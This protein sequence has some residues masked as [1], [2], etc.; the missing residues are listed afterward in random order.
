MLEE[1]LP[2]HVLAG[3]MRILR[4][5]ASAALVAEE[6]EAALADFQFALRLADYAR[7]QPWVM[8]TELQMRGV[9]DT[10][11][12]LWEGLAARRWDERQLAAAQAQLE[13]LDL[14]SDF[15]RSVRNDAIAQSSFVERI[16]PT[17]S[18]T[19]RVVP[20]PSPEDAGA[21]PMIRLVYPKGWSLQSQAAIHRFHLET[22][23]RYL[24]ADARRLAV[25]RREKPRG[26]FASSD[27]LYRVFMV[28][29]ML[30]IFVD[31]AEN[32]PFAQTA[33]DLATLACALERYRLAQGEFPA[34]LAPLEPRF[35]A[36][37]PHDI[38][39]GEP[40]KYRRTEAGGFVVY[41]VGFNRVDDGGKPCMRRVNGRGERESRLDLD[42]ND[43]VW[44]G[45]AAQ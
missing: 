11:Q 40:L 24:D 3:F 42:E 6:N 13:A 35:V 4:L 12:P 15:P 5:R 20:L 41:S 14:L 17:S 45:P 21:L 10:L 38:I 27:P 39:T 22:T 36:T 37:L 32:F 18:A 29:K 2:V 23:S 31:S 43:W 30:H 28:P 26:L 34:T 33:V 1:A 16:F 9:V 19:P 7:Q 25:K 8:Q 44:A